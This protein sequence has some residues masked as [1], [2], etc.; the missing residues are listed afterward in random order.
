MSIV[1]QLDEPEVGQVGRP[2]LAACLTPQELD[3][4]VENGSCELVDGEPVERN[5]GAEAEWIAL[6]IATE[7]NVHLRT[8]DVG[9]AFASNV[10]YRIDPEQSRRTRKPDAS[11]ISYE[12]SGSRDVPRVWV[13][14]PPEVAVEVVSPN[15]VLATLRDK[16]REYFRCGVDEVWIVSPD[17]REI[18]IRTADSV[19][20]LREHQTLHASG[21]LAG[22]SFRVGDVFPPAE[23]AAGEVSGN[24]G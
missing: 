7:F 8:H 18:E 9:H 22:L 10:G 24:G 21:P 15:D 19:S 16:V 20:V 17:D 4:L 2:S 14:R 23:T 13:R 1:P 11:F 6:Q 3:R 12:R 5:M